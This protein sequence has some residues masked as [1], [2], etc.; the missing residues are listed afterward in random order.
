MSTQINVKCIDQTLTLVSTPLIASGG[1]N[2]D[3]VNFAFC[4]KWDGFSKT[5][6]FYRTPENV[7]Y[8]L[9]D[10]DNVCVIP[11]EVLKED[12]YLF[13]GVFGSNA[14]GVTRTSEVLRYKI[15]KGA[16]TENIKPS[17][18][19]PSIYEQLL[20]KYQEIL[21]LCEE[22]ATA[23]REFE[24]LITNKHNAF[25]ASINK[26]QTDFET[27]INNQFN[28][29]KEETNASINE[30][31]SV[32][33]RFKGSVQSVDDLP[34]NA[35]I[36]D[37][38]NVLRS[39]NNYAWTG[40]E[41]DALGGEYD[42]SLFYKNLK[43]G[44]V[45]G[46]SASDKGIEL[47]EVQGKSVQQKT[48]GYQLFDASKLPTTSKGGATV[49]NNGD[50]SFTISGSGTVTKTF[51]A[52]YHYSRE[53]TVKLLKVGKIT[54]NFRAKS[55]PVL[56]LQL[57]SPTKLH[58]EL[59]N[60]SASERSVTIT[61]EMLDDTTAYLAISFYAETGYQIIPATIKPMIYQDGD[62]TWEPFTGGEPAPNPDYP[63]E[64]KDTDVTK[65]VTGQ[66]LLDITKLSPH[67]NIKSTI[68][69]E[70]KIKLEALA[71]T[72]DYLSLTQPVPKAL[73]DTLRGKKLI[74]K[75]TVLEQKNVNNPCLQMNIEK[76]D[77]S[78]KYASLSNQVVEI[79]D[80]IEALTFGLYANDSGTPP[81]VGGYAIFDNVG[82]YIY[83]ENSTDLNLPYNLNTLEANLDLRSLPNGVKDTYENGVITR[84]VGKCMAGELD[85]N[86]IFQNDT[87]ISFSNLTFLST[88]VISPYLPCNVLE[89]SDDHD[90]IQSARA[91]GIARNNAG[92]YSYAFYIS[93]KKSRLSSLDNAGLKA[94]LNANNAYFYY[95]LKEPVI[96]KVDNLLA[97]SYY[98]YTSAFTDNE[99]ETEM[100]W[101]LLNDGD[102]QIEIDELKKEVSD[103]YATKTEL[104]EAIG[105]AIGGTY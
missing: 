26:K 3:V 72:V 95:E 38:Y 66:N 46:G 36:G 4:Q 35:S 105:N 29:Y 70:N 54:A 51:S 75:W 77:G 102:N 104:V 41:W 62:G 10:S 101:R 22:T 79:T 57:R 81:S 63:M 12:G 58:F 43:E 7:Y 16:I 86:V 27:S 8:S 14:N 9:L 87:Y 71:N 97:P 33:Y 23:E 48:N 1:I 67:A 25:E 90:A 53:E 52:A 93:V 2:E 88:G 60:G 19:T 85:Y 98:P 68:L 103:T 42:T 13:F 61:Q 49:T 40:T 45:Y 73:L 20:A 92:I 65:V 56:F 59:V 11:Q 21:D 83:D 100:K 96:E 28:D 24:T 44:M 15:E 32:V 80:D 82:I 18:P 39:G 69:G 99:I 17:D 84:R 34:T 37:V 64:I 78:F 6:V 94:F 89:P 91:E 5:A 31:L 74:N 76:S 50:G 55:M 30:K 47:Y